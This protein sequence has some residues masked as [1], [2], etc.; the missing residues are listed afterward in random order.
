MGTTP[1]SPISS[2]PPPPEI[3]RF[4]PYGER[5][6]VIS[7]YALMV[8]SVA[9]FI[10]L[11][12]LGIYTVAVKKE[13]PIYKSWLDFISFQTTTIVLLIIG[14]V[15]A[16]VGRRILSSSQAAYVRTIPRDDFAL[17]SQA[18]IEG[19]PE[20]I[21]QYVRLRSLTGW[22]GT[23]TKLGITGLPL[24]TVF[25]TLIFSAASLLPIP[26]ANGF[27]DLAKLTLGAFIGSFVQR[28][29]EQRKQEQQSGGVAPTVSKSDLPA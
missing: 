20:P 3:I 27:M 12:A 9:S 1:T 26:N 10:S 21:D 2:L 6:I 23:F 11:I 7:G 29:V 19:K 22:A 5:I 4:S 17:I 16:L 18:V 14:V 8:S 15:T 13:T 24:V 28:S 25:L